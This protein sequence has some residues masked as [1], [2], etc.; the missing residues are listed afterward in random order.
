MKL[1]KLHLSI[2]HFEIVH[3]LLHFTILIFSSCCGGP[4]YIFVSH[5]S[6]CF[7]YC[8]WSETISLCAAESYIIHLLPCNLISSDRWDLAESM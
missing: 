4:Q 8:A 6:F 1:K 2:C 7:S 3:S 5:L